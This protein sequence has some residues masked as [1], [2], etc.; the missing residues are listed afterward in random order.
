MTAKDLPNRPSTDEAEA[1]VSIAPGL[2]LHIP[3]CSK[4][5]PYCDFSVLTGTEERKAQFT[6]NLC[7]EIKSWRGEDWAR[8]FDTIYFGGGTPSALA[9]EGIF[10]IL[11]TLES[12]LDLEDSPWIQFE[13]NPEDCSKSTTA[14]W[15]E[16]GIDVLSLGVQSFDDD[17]LAFLGRRHDGRGARLA[18]ETALDAGFSAVSIDLIFGLPGQTPA[19][20]QQDLEAAI[21]LGPQHISC[22]QLTIHEG[23]S[24]GF[25]AQ[26]GQL[27]EM[28]NEDQAELFRIT[29]RRLAEHGYAAYEVSNFASAP[30][31]RSR[32]N[33]KYWQ[34]VPYLGFGPSAHSYRGRRRWWNARK[35]PNW[36]R[37]VEAGQRPI[38]DAETLDSS[39]FLLEALML[40]LRTTRGVDFDALSQ[41]H[42]QD[43]WTERLPVIERLVGQGFLTVHGRSIAPTLE[44]LAIAETLVSNLV[45][46]LD[47][48]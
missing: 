48:P 18:V 7:R 38:E 27:S 19:R 25:R 11:E 30:R 16:L 42:S 28:P 31:F 22:Y 17:Q 8:P 34:H 40:G 26:R 32:H 4:I 12:N 6:V 10:E 13:A 33:Q 47:I 20:W 45:S 36:Q 37:L 2:Y 44:G 24:F 29:H 21:S 9:P 46:N 41:E 15:R 39:Q 3:F 1:S 43:L 14:S 35:L 5:C 23:T